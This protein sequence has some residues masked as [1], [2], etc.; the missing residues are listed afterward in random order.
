[1]SLMIWTYN[2]SLVVLQEVLKMIKKAKTDDKV[3]MFR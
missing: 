2:V 1:M 3:F